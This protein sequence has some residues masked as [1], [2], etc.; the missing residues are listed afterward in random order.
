MD[1]RTE[2]DLPAF[3]RRRAD[4]ARRYG[5][6]ARRRRADAIETP[7]LRAYEHQQADLREIQATKL[8]QLAGQVETLLEA[9]AERRRQLRDGYLAEHPD[10]LDGLD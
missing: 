7:H 4:E 3:L 10:G 6:A 9:Q 8:E 1:V 2:H 5:A